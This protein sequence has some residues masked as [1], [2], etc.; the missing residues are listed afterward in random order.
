[1]ITATEDAVVDEPEGEGDS[2]MDTEVEE[3]ADTPVAAEDD[4]VLTEQREPAGFGV[5]LLRSG[6]GMPVI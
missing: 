6:D 2:A 4:Q 1:V 3:D 5:Y